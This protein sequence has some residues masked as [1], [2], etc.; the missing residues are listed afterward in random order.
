MLFRTLRQASQEREKLKQIA[1]I[2]TS[3]ES[4]SSSSDVIETIDYDTNSIRKI[5][6]GMANFQRSTGVNV[7]ALS[8]HIKTIGRDLKV[9]NGVSSLIANAVVI[10]I[11]N[12]LNQAHKLSLIRNRPIDSDYTKCTDY[13]M[14]QFAV[15]AAE[16]EISN[17]DTTITDSE[18]VK[19]E[20]MNYV[21]KLTGYAEGGT[22]SN[23]P[24]LDAKCDVGLEPYLPPTNRQKSISIF[25]L[26]QAMKLDP[27]MDI[28]KI[29]TS[30]ATSRI[31]KQKQNK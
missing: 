21:H 29:Q 14:V 18:N 6:F 23:Q 16:Q 19:P 2:P 3:S 24:D 15:L 10:K 27:S 12:L 20:V 31:I 8:M 5:P 26:I 1:L 11:F 25:D 9:S 22:L 28:R 7:P 17:G 30:V 4:D 13:P